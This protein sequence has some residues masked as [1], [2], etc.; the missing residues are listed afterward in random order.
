MPRGRVA[1]RH[2]RRTRLDAVVQQRGRAVVLHVADVLGREAGVGERLAHRARRL[3]AGLV[4]AHAVVGVARRAVAADLGEHPRAARARPLERLEDEHPGALA[5]DE[6]VAPRVEGAARRRRGVQAGRREDLHEREA[7]HDAG[8]DDG[9]GAAREDEVLVAPRDEPRRVGER[10]GRGRAARRDHVRAA[11]EAEA[12]RDLGGERPHRAGRDRVDGGLL[13]VAAVPVAVHP[14]EEIHGAAARAEDDGDPAP[15]VERQP[16]RVDSRARERLAGGRE[17]ERDDAPDVPELLRAQR[18]LGVE[19]LHLGGDRHVE[20]GRVEERD[21]GDAGPSGAQTL[22]ER[23]DAV[24][25][26]R[27]AAEARHADAPTSSKRALRRAAVRGDEVAGFERG[28]GRK[29]EEGVRPRVGED[30]VTPLRRDRARR[31]PRRLAARARPG[32]TRG[33]APCSST[34]PARRAG[35]GGRQRRQDSGRGSQRGPHEEV[36]ARRRPRPDCR[37]GRRRASPLS[38]R[39]ARASPAGSRPCESGSRRPRSSRALAT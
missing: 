12:H 13:Q 29:L 14:L 38:S 1:E 6:P 8:R 23:G 28:P 34:G 39:R 4:E 19:A 32:G 26:R 22:R 30:V 37:A 27:E 16:F 3:L 36:E 31:S 5:E 15:L 18:G 17:R 33:A 21:P 10:I 2:L 24:S 9:V 11:L 25:D 35:S 7:G 20:R